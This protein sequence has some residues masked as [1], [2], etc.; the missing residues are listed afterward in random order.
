MLIINSIF[1][2]TLFVLKEMSVKIL[3]RKTIKI[4]YAKI[5]YSLSSQT[6]KFTKIKIHN[7]YLHYNFPKN[8]TTEYIY[9]K[10]LH[11]KTKSI[12]NNLPTKQSP[13]EPK[14]TLIA[15]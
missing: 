7:F 3:S 9:K 13:F 11:S 2:F 10:N 8:K 14:S 12:R 6:L 15:K 5:N 1:P 4:L